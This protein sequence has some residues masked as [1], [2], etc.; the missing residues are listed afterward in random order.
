[1]K[2]SSHIRIVESG[3][4]REGVAVVAFLAALSL[5]GCTSTCGGGG[6]ANPG[7]ASAPSAKI[8]SAGDATQSRREFR[9]VEEEEEADEARLR[10]GWLKALAAYRAPSCSVAI[11]RVEALL[12][13]GQGRWKERTDNGALPGDLAAL[14]S[15]A[16]LWASQS[17]SVCADSPMRP[18]F[19]ALRMLMDSIWQYPTRVSKTEFEQRLTVLGD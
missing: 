18:R 4:G 12:K 8:E 6:H 13:R 14:L 5:S 19:D 9:S 17:E 3:C 2:T 16:E 11:D 10:A 7:Q 1:M 15:E